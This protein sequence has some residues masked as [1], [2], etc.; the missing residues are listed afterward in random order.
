MFTF[1]IIKIIFI[2]VFL[3]FVVGSLWY[4]WVN[5]LNSDEDNQAGNSF[6]Y[7][8]DWEIYK[9]DE[10]L[11]KVIITCYFALTT[12]STVGFGDL[13][14]LSYIEM[15]FGI[16]IMLTGQVVFSGVIG[17]F[18]EILQ[19]YNK[20]QDKVDKSIELHNWMNLLSRFTNNKPLPEK[21]IKKIDNHYAFFWTNDRLRFLS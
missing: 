13:K 10:V 14:P 6:I 5:N 1:R 9:T 11:Q 19:S 4:V 3:T 2:F 15:V 12:L 8:E 7:N 17:Q 21:L 16:I 18:Q 20:I